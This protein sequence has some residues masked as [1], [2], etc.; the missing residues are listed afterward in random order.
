M[1]DLGDMLG[2]GEIRFFDFRGF[3]ELADVSRLDNLAANFRRLLLNAYT[4]DGWLSPGD[5]KKKKDMMFGWAPG[6]WQPLH[7]DVSDCEEWC[8]T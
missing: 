2:L 6:A 5:A 4:E 3:G 7:F 8:C 1:M